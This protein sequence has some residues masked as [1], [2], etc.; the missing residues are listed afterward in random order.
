MSSE[1]GNWAIRVWRSITGEFRHQPLGATYYLLAGLALLL[2]AVSAARNILTSAFPAVLPYL[3]GTPYLITAAVLLLVVPFVKLRKREAPEPA[4][5]S[6][7]NPELES[8][9][10]TFEV[11]AWKTGRKVVRRDRIRAIAPTRY[12]TYRFRPT[13]SV[14]MKARLVEPRSAKLTGPGPQHDFI[15]YRVEFDAPLAPGRVVDVCLEYDVDDTSSTMSPFHSFVGVGFRKVTELRN[16]VRFPKDHAA[17]VTFE[18]T[19]WRT[20]S[21]TN[22]QTG[23]LLPDEKGEYTWQPTEV[24]PVNIYYVSWRWIQ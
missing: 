17:D 21:L 15:F 5:N 12:F 14:T 3:P 9:L 4:P 10:T 7:L 8:L 19:D 13:G 24:S 2:T 16:V 18:I 6:V 23:R 1:E 20:G 22:R 11:D